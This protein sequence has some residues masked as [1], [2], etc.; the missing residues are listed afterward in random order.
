MICE[1]DL[2]VRVA[3]AALDELV[4]LELLDRR[5]L[6]IQIVLLPTPQVEGGY[7]VIPYSHKINWALDRSEADYFVYLDNGSMPAPEKFEAMARTLDEN[8]GYHST[9][10]AQHR[11]GMRDEKFHLDGPL[12]NPYGRLNFTQVMHRVTAC[13]WT[14]DMKHANPDLA[15]A[16]FFRDLVTDHGAIYPADDPRVLD[17][18]HIP[19]PAA[20]HLTP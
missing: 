10:C 12:R 1:T 13:R 2:D 5:P 16:I 11:T 8:P 9:Y 7:E 3:E 6:W 18:H 20:G 14:L 4:E 19:S 17:V 15:D